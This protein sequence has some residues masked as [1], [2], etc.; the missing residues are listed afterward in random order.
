MAPEN[1]K[2][3]LEN[4]KRYEFLNAI[5][6]LRHIPTR[7]RGVGL[8]TPKIK[9]KHVLQKT[10]F[11]ITLQWFTLK[12]PSTPRVAWQ[13]SIPLHVNNQIVTERRFY[14]FTR[15]SLYGSKVTTEFRKPA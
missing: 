7:G 9:E 1:R 15:N 6:G 5:F 4:R 14:F 11:S 13:R 3:Y 2:S 10:K 12:G 8:E